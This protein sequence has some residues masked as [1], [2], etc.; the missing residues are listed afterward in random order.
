MNKAQTSWERYKSQSVNNWNNYKIYFKTKWKRILA[1]YIIMLIAFTIIYTI[2][3]VTKTLLFYHVDVNAMEAAGNSTWYIGN[4]TGID[5]EK[6]Y[7]SS[8]EWLKYGIIGIRSIWHKGV[9]FMSTNNIV[10]IQ[11]LSFIIAI[12][13]LLVPLYPSKYIYWY[14]VF[15]GILLAGD[16][17]NATDR[18]AFSGYVKDWFY[19]PWYD[20]GTMNFADVSVIFSVIAIV[21]TVLTTTIIDWNKERKNNK[22]DIES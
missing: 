10:F 5:P 17:G 21:I 4:H 2:D 19:F 13:I 20:R 16:L 3:Q 6:I 14:A 22:Q 9:T 11:V 18:I 8:N 7:P 12:G 1:A 15:Y